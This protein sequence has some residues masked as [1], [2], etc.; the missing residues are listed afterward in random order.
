MRKTIWQKFN[1]KKICRKCRIELTDDNWAPSSQKN[2]SYICKSCSN[3]FTKEL[4]RINGRKYYRYNYNKEKLQRRRQEERL[5]IL[6]H[7]SENPPKCSR[8]GFT[9]VRALQIDHINGG[10]RRQRREDGLKHGQAMYRWIKKNNYP[11]GFQI[12]CAN[13]NWIKKHENH[14]VFSNWKYNQPQSS[15]VLILG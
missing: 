7:Y 2:H 15:E 1:E 10:G 11:D 6:I 9:D 5:G 8:C 14:E 12:L 4:R 13:C 3:I